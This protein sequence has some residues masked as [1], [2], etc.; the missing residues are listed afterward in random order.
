MGVGRAGRPGPVRTKSA[1]QRAVATMRYRPFVSYT[2]RAAGSDAEPARSAR[3][4]RPSP[5]S[6]TT[7]WTRAVP[8]TVHGPMLVVTWSSSGPSYQSH[9]SRPVRPVGR[10]LM[11]ILGGGIWRRAAR[12]ISPMLGTGGG[13]GGAGTLPSGFSARQ[14]TSWLTIAPERSVT[15][16]VCSQPGCPNPASQLGP[17]PAIT[18]AGTHVYLYGAGPFESPALTVPVPPCPGAMIPT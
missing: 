13:A 5:I 1:P 12:Q 2:Y 16:S 15:T 18:P 17:R 3:A 11:P 9:V 6:K 14:R 8:V 7:S 4:V 10:G